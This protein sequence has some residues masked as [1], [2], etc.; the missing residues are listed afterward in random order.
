[1]LL[2][3]IS[4]IAAGCGSSEKPPA[5][6]GGR[7]TTTESAS[8]DPKQATRAE[9]ICKQGL[10]EIGVLSRHLAQSL[11]NS[12]STDAI[13]SEL[14]APGIKILDRKA[15]RFDS[16]RA[17][18]D[19]PDFNLYIGLFD[20][21]IELAEQRLEAG[22]A[23]EPE[24]GQALERLI[25]GLGDEQVTVARRLRLDACTVSFTEALGGQR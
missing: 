14:V 22:R 12:P 5:Q 1:L 10:H 4:L 13:G 9:S 11:G 15:S 16:L 19:S 3:A 25:A 18:S 8:L 7:G 2:L 23:E 6:R 17:A 21:I 24:R 20:P